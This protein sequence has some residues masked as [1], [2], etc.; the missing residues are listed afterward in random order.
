MLL[1]TLRKN[2]TVTHI[3]CDPVLR[4]NLPLATRNVN[5]A[6]AFSLETPAAQLPATELAPRPPGTVE[7]AAAGNGAATDHRAS[8]DAEGVAQGTTTEEDTPALRVP[9]KEA[10]LG[11]VSGKLSILPVWS[12]NIPG[13]GVSYL[14]FWAWFIPRG[15]PGLGVQIP[16]LRRREL[17]SLAAG[18]RG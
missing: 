16:A 3:V 14:T 17:S 1:G 7:S 6:P 4:V 11:A 2:C 9:Q 15:P 8:V 10:W 5:Q 12:R 18:R 13:A